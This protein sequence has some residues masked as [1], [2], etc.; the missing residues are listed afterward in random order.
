MSTIIADLNGGDAITADNDL[1]YKVYNDTDSYAVG[2]VFGSH[3]SDSNVSV[4]AGSV[5]IINV[6][7]PSGVSAYK[8][9][10][11]DQAGNESILS[12]A[13]STSVAPLLDTYTTA[14]GAWSLQQ[15]KTGV[16]A[17]IEVERDS[18]LTRADFTAAEITDG[19]LVAWVGA[20]NNGNVSIFYDQSG[21]GDDLGQGTTDKMPLIV[22][23]GV[24]VTKD[25]NPACLST[26]TLDG[27][28]KSGSN[29]SS[30]PA[31]VNKSI[32]SVMS[33]NNDSIRQR[34]FTFAV[35]TVSNFALWFEAATGVMSFTSD[36]YADRVE[37]TT[38]TTSTVLATGI[39]VGT[40]NTIWANGTVGGTNELGGV[41]SGTQTLGL[42]SMATSIADPF[43]GYFNE[44]IIFPD[45]QTA[46]RVAIET[47]INSRYTIF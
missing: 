42:M 11:I 30:F 39:N 35:S 20:G 24:L 32:F 45:D 29:L 16:T 9:S 8:I 10:S 33:T 3:V 46:N 2:E 22:N 14:V 25:G 12:A 17:V 21:S 43:D 37:V 28:V 47:N 5:T 41:T 36:A 23:A 31:N 13:F 34:F 18:D 44:L 4:S 7:E 38:T 15:L 40:K 1:T 27:L 19:T 6:T 26:G